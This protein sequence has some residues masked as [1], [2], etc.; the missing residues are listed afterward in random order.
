M[1]LC[2]DALVLHRLYGAAGG[3]WLWVMAALTVVGSGWTMV[4]IAAT[5]AHPKLRA[6][7]LR[8][9][10]MLALV[11]IAVFSLKAL[12]GRARPCACLTDVHALVFSAPT[13]PS[14]PSGHAAG[15]FA[16]ATYVA[17]E[18]RIHVA[19]KVALFVVAAGIAASRIV[20]GVHYPSDVVAGAAL[21]AVAAFLYSLS[22]KTLAKSR[23]DSI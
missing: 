21:G 8:L 5:A 17:L 3:A 15:A 7:A 19:G 2:V 4:P 20:L 12:F 1:S 13:D 22:R 10:S 9:V 14:F 11:A 6:H 23:R 18:S 16:V